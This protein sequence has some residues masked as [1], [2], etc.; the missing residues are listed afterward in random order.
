MT[1]H[2]LAPN[3]CRHRWLATPWRIARTLW[4]NDA[5]LTAF[6]LLL[7]ALMLP[8]AVAMGLD[9]R[10]LRGVNVWIKPLKFMASIA[11]LALTTAWF[12]GHLHRERRGS[13]AVSVIVWT[14]IGSGAFE[15]AYITW[16][17]G[18]GQGSHFNVGDPLH[19]TMYTLMGIGALAL[20]ATQ[21]ALAWQLARHGERTL[22]SAYRLAVL[23]GLTLTFVLGAAAGMV[24]SSTQPPTGAGLPLF[25]WSRIGGDF[26]VA[27]FIGIHTE[28]VLPL[29][30]AA[31]AAWQV[32]AGRAWVVAAALVW[33]GLFVLAFVQALRGLPLLG[34]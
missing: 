31:L 30:G 3:S 10:V 18:L 32:R 16:Q 11:V 15:L 33:S 9:D 19:A 7:I 21:P 25:G 8:A 4:R 26:R 14:V 6:A 29:F 28:Q 12:I 23:L 13:R 1:T 20:T 5:R 2:A 27:H 24:L 34:L 22:P 17:A